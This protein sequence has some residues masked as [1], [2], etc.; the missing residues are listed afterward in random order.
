[1]LLQIVMIG[2]L[3][4]KDIADGWT[5]PLGTDLSGYGAWYTLALAVGAGWLAKVLLVDAVISP[6][7]TGV[8]YVATTARLSYALGEERE[9]PSALAT[10]NRKGVTVVSI[11]VAAGRGCLAFGTVKRWGRGVRRIP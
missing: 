3:A 7:G 4:P 6:A 11:L 8:V 5:Q 10:T 1:S 9:M 2:A